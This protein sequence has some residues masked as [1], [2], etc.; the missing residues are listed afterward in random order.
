MIDITEI[1]IWDYGRYR[2]ISVI[3]CFSRKVLVHAFLMRLRAEEVIELLQQALEK[4]QALC[5]QLTE[6]IFLIT[7][8][9]T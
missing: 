9:G 8:D 5:G 3:D 1:D 7:D 2:L 4:A 6:K